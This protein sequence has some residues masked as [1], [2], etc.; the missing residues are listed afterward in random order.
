MQPVVRPMSK[1][2]AKHGIPRGEWEMTS[3]HEVDSRAL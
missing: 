2:P 3:R 1:V